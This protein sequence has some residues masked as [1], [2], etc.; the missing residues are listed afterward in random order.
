MYYESYFGLNE[1]PFSIS[2]DPRYLYLTAGH[3]EALA[4]L[5]YGVMGSGGFVLLTGEVG[6]GKTTVCRCLLQQLPDNVEVALVLNP[7]LDVLEFFAAICDELGIELNKDKDTGLK[8]LVDHIY[9]YLL[10]A[11]SQGRNTVLIVDEAQ[12]LAPDLIE[13]LRLLTNLETDEKKLLQIILIGQPELRELLAAPA[14]RQM[15][16]RITA[17]F[18]LQLLSKP[19]AVGY[20]RHRLGVAGCE[21]QL[22]DGKSIKYI[23][24]RSGG[25]PRLMNA[26]CDRALLGASLNDRK[27]VSV[28]IARKAADEVLG[29]H[30]RSRKS[31]TASPL[32]FTVLIL[33]LVSAAFVGA[34]FMP[35]FS[36]KL[37]L[38]EWPGR[39]GFVPGHSG[40]NPDLSLNNEDLNM[41]GEAVFQGVHPE[42]GPGLNP[43][44]ERQKEELSDF[45]PE[46]LDLLQTSPGNGERDAFS[47]LFS[48]WEVDYLSQDMPT[49]CQ[50]AKTIGMACF[51][52]KGSLQNLIAINRPVIL[53]LEVN[54][55][56]N[57]LITVQSI[58]AGKAR[59]NLFGN[60]KDVE[61]D[62]L[63]KLWTGEFLVIL[64]APKGFE[65][66]VKLGM[67]GDVVEWVTKNISATGDS[68]TRFYDESVAKRVRSFQ[69][70]FGLKPDGEVGPMTLIAINDFKGSTGPRLN[71]L[72]ALNPGD[73]PDS[74][75]TALSE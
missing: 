66:V 23:W 7:K 61:I 74:K 19:E 47:A 18:H 41:R 44:G 6:A 50:Y 16:Q 22:F 38:G 63:L 36:D 49:D 59:I 40:Q 69:Q 73:P 8:V 75:L 27:Q 35:G 17:R 70:V 53:T 4:H 25:V 29:E 12:N 46:L 14:L 3:R 72:S 55:E 54:A 13:H 39:M 2:P 31:L 5:L 37:S 28:K 64:R 30:G 33:C 60:N 71:D 68:T 56:K 45:Q 9:S 62:K 32:R 1:S 20:I 52:G 43:V 26:I 10:A 21:N 34:I 48:E 57:H 15:A 42:P 65:G 11:H 58:V 24:R 51:T 67:E